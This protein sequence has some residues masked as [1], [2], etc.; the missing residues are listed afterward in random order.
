VFVPFCPGDSFLEERAG[1][2]FSGSGFC[3]ELGFRA[4]DQ[5][6]NDRVW[7]VDGHLSSRFVLLIEKFTQSRG[8][9]PIPLMSQ[10]AGECE[11]GLGFQ[12]GKLS[13]EESTEMSSFV[14]GSSWCNAGAATFVF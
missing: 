6:E 2:E 1:I 3:G 11:F 14:I 9:P 5:N 13:C 7:F 10:V 8:G 4:T 12:G